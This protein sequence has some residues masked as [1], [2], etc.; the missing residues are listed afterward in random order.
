M[1]PF[2]I[3]AGIT[4]TILGLLAIILVVGVYV[5]VKY[6]GFQL[7]FGTFKQY[8]NDERSE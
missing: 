8:N 1:T 7:T 3:I 4:V 2:F 5:A 6:F